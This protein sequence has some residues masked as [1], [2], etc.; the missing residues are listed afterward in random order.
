MYGSFH[1]FRHYI[2]IVRERS[3]CLMRDAQLR[4]SREN[5]VDG[6]VV[7][8]DVMHGAHPVTGHNTPIHNVLSTAPRLSVSRR[9]L[10][11]LPEDGN[12]MPKHVGATIHD[13]FSADI[14]WL[15]YVTTPEGERGKGIWSYRFDDNKNDKKKTNLISYGWKVHLEWIARGTKWECVVSVGFVQLLRHQLAPVEFFL[16]PAWRASWKAHVLP[17][18]RQSNNMW[19]QFCDRFLNRPLLTVYR[20]F[21]N[22]ANSVLWRMATILKA[23]KVNLFVSSVLFVFWC[24]SPDFLDTPCTLQINTKFRA[25]QQCAPCFNPPCVFLQ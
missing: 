11:A 24:H 2:A 12:V 23:N 5:I 4:S 21:M 1:K 20:S 19:Q 8:S 10:G 16:F 9:A 14:Y 6:R 25:G 3:K 13:I 18:W 17:T 7:L 15:I 22:V